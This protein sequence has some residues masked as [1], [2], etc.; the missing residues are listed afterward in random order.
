MVIL[1]LAISKLRKLK[2][3]DLAITTTQIWLHLGSFAAFTGTSILLLYAIH[4]GQVKDWL[5]GGIKN[6]CEASL[7]RD[8]TFE[9]TIELICVF[10]IMVSE[11]PIIHIVNTLVQRNI[12]AVK[13]ETEEV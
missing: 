3:N 13:I 1:T 8:R 11:L 7:H 9:I 6:Y 10:F 12:W 2:T 4:A 5:N